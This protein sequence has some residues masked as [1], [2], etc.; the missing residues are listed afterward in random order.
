M[1]KALKIILAVFL[2][3]VILSALGLSV[4]FLDLASYSATGGETLKVS[5]M[6][7]GM[8]LVVYDPGITGAAKDIASKIASDIQDYGYQVELVGI[9]NTT[10][11]SVIANQY[12]VIVVGGPIYGG[13]A[14]SSVQSYLSKLN[15]G[16]GAS[17]GVFGVGSFNTSN[18]QLYPT[19]HNLTVKY[20]LK[21]GTS[22]NASER[23][24]FFVDQLLH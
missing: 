8:A 2:A 9:R 16:N 24:F 4:V 15:A 13:K 10:A 12:N 19:S 1:R 21:I 17:V 23:C 18:D 20:S 22:E 6:G 14:S 7:F 5:K 3:F 11:S